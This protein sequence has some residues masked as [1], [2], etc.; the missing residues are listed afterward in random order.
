LARIIYRSVPEGRTRLEWTDSNVLF[1][2][3]YLPGKLPDSPVKIPAQYQRTLGQN[4]TEVLCGKT[5]I[6]GLQEIQFTFLQELKNSL[7]DAGTVLIFYRGRNCIPVALFPSG[8]SM[9]P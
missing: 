5:I 6:T 2:W 9:K 8:I 7:K 3:I 4:I 1:I